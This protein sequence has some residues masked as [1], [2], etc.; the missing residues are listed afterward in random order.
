MVRRHDRT[1]VRDGRELLLDV[2][3]VEE[4]RTDYGDAGLLCCRELRRQQPGIWRTFQQDEVRVARDTLLHTC[5][6]LRW[7][8]A[9]RVLDELHSGG[10][11]GLRLGFVDDLIERVGTQ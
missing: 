11:C 2:A 1:Q 4:V 7:C 8:A 6:P 9:V 10:L 3:H 5:N